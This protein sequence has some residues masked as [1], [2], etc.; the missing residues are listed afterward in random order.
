MHHPLSCS[1]MEA[2]KMSCEPSLGVSLNNF[3]SHMASEMAAMR[4]DINQLTS[5]VE[6]LPEGAKGTTVKGMPSGGRV[7]L[8]CIFRI[9]CSSS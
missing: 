1:T 3:L 8:R 6:G 5:V 9:L 7:V 4:A 2:T